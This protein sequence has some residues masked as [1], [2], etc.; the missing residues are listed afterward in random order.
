[1]SDRVYGWI[2]STP[3]WRDAMFRRHHAPMS[4]V[5]RPPSF[6]LAP[7][8]PPVYDQ[9][10]TGSCVGN[11]CVGIFQYN[12]IRQNFPVWTPSRL[13][14]YWNARALEGSTASDCGAQVRDGIKGLISPGVCSE[15]EWPF[16]PDKVTVSPSPQNFADAAANMVT[17]YQSLDQIVDL[18]CSTIAGGEPFVFGFAC[19]TAFESKEVESSGILGMPGST[20]KIIGG[21]CVVAVGYDDDKRMFK[22]RNSWGKAWG[23]GGY[24]WMPYDYL[25]N[26]DLAADF[27]VINTTTG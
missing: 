23:Q 14:A 11:G 15:E 1:M 20:E 17:S 13:F 12:L 7:I 26:S 18:F 24:F 6:D 3:D 16:D 5:S 27:W 21:H 2:H 22:I 25:G 10:K 8:F 4:L 9:G 19:Y